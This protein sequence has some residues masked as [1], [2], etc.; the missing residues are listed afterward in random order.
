VCY[1]PAALARTPLAPMI[2]TWWSRHAR[3]GALL[4]LLVAAGGLGTMHPSHAFTVAVPTQGDGV[5]HHY[6]AGAVEYLK[7]LEFEGNLMTP[8]N[9]GAYVSWHLF[10]A[11]KVG[12]DSRY[13]VAYPPEFV[14]EGILVYEGEG[15]WQEFLDRHPT[16]AVLVPTGGP[17]DSLLVEASGETMPR[18]LEVYRDDSYAVFAGDH[19][20]P[21]MPRQDRRGDEIRGTFP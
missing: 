14:E 6:P 11:V 7:G 9:V 15:N 1:V 13:E 21:E 12:L 5:R 20:A 17:L 10:P 16:D 8:F 3:A 19:R 18:W 2:R 4:A